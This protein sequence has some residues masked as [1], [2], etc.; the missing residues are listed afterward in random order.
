MEDRNRQRERARKLEEER[1]KRLRSKAERDQD[2]DMQ[3]VHDGK[4][5]I[6]NV[7]LLHTSSLCGPHK[8]RVGVNVADRPFFP[9]SDPTRS[10][11]RSSADGSSLGAGGSGHALSRPPVPRLSKVVIRTSNS[12]QSKDL[13][14][15]AASSEP[16]PP[17]DQGMNTRTHTR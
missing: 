2:S 9:S 16:V 17:E 13:S 8:G 4:E 3:R 1:R 12:H 15:G 5:P 10:R 11:G 14:K 6:H 7:Q